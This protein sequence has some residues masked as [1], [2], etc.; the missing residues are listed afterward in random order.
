MRRCDWLGM[1]HPKHTLSEQIEQLVWEHIEV[2]RRAAAAAV[3][4]SFSSSSATRQART[5]VASSRT[6]SRTGSG[7]RS[8]AELSALGERLHEAVCGHPGEAMSVLAPALGKTPRE[9]QRPMTV[10]KRAGRVRS[11]GQRHQTRYFPTVA[12]PIENAS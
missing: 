10:L 8:V 3:E 11:V 12:R 7:R 1:S 4:R 5:H 6:T 9:L 2:M